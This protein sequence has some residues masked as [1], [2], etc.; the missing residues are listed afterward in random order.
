MTHVKSPEASETGNDREAI[1]SVLIVNY[2]AYDELAA[3]LDSLER[4]TVANLDV[5]VVDH[6]TD[7]ASCDRLKERAPWARFTQTAA[8]PGFAAGVNR[9]AAMAHGRFLYLLNPDTVADP[10]VCSTL[11]G[12]LEHHP[13][14]GAVGSLVRDPDGSL[15][16]SAR[17]FPDVT[18][19]LAGRTTW[20]T[21]LLPGNSMSRRNL[22]TAPHVRSPIQVDWVSGASVMIRREAFEAIGGMDEGFFLYWEDADLCHRLGQAGWWTTYHPESGVTHLCGRSSRSNAASIVAFHRSA[23]RYYRKHGGVAARLCAPI[24]YVLLNIRMLLLLSA[25]AER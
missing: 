22:L 15:Q 21:R 16:A 7:A 8:N 17:R 24:V 5:I 3:C 13:E 4:Q 2:H 18:T 23:Y 12:W 9:A 25:R 6:D 19:A 10:E 20:L 1:V 14:V 11:V